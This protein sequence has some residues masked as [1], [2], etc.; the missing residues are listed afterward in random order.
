MGV[1][2][3]DVARLAGVSVATV[4]R[5]LNASGPVNVDTRDRIVR[6]AGTLRFAPNG[7]A[8]SLSRRESRVFGVILPDLYG[9]FFSELLR[10]V[11]QEAQRSGYALL[12]SSSHHDSR[13]VES[14]VRSMRGRVDGLIVMAPDVPATALAAALPEDVPVVLLNAK[15]LPAAGAC[16]TVDNEG[17]A[18]AV[19]RHLLALGHREFAFVAGPRRNADAQARLRGYRMALRNGG[20]PHCGDR[21]AR[22]DFTEDGG[23][24]AARALFA[25]NSRPPTAL[26]AANDAMAVGALAS[27]R[28]AGISVPE[29]VSVVG[30]DDIPI[31][32]YTNPPLTTVHVA[33]DIL[34]ARAAALLRRALAERTATSR[35][36][37]VPAELV[38]RH[39]CGPP[40]SFHYAS[41][42]LESTSAFALS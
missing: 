31:A 6:A 32:R 14:A 42:A 4:S 16:V 15:T 20:L 34:G 35:R 5:A 28:E 38:V 12:V 13:G 7:A 41:P 2:I 9:E 40:P 18:T 24:R 37:V 29:Q 22:G 10:G 30:F 17:G 1:T 19:V 33:I 8:R 21:V 11:D 26:F 27:L 3:K 36:E 39:S 23:W 25:G